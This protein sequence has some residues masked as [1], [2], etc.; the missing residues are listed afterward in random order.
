[1][2][3][4]FIIRLSNLAILFHSYECHCTSRYSGKN[5]EIDTGPPCASDPCK[6]GG[7]CSE[8]S[9][10]NYHCTCAP[11]FTGSFCETQISIH[12]L[13]VNNPCQNNGTCKV[14]PNANRWECECLPGFTGLSCET[15]F[16]ECESQPCFNDGEC[17]DEMGGF[18]CNCAGTGYSGTFCQINVD[19]CMISSPCLNGGVCFDTYGSY[20]CE[21]QPGFGGNNCEQQVNEC[22]S[23]PCGNGT[24]IDLKGGRYNCICP[25]GYSGLNCENGPPCPREC[26]PDTECIAGQCVCLTDSDGNCVS[27]PTQKLAPSTNCNCLN[28]G[29]CAGTTS[30]FSCICPKNYTGNE[31]QKL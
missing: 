21:C 4:F 11:G 19:E 14:S 7:G 29:S 22:L 27:T 3:S 31:T 13:C 1:M 2:L 20:T 5:C 17:V 23:H 28:G 15:D 16:N 6:N 26:P 9:R 25:L 18:K 10:G 8:D 30:N 24:C 12:P